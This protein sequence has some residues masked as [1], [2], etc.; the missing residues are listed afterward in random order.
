MNSA[1]VIPSLHPNER[2]IALVKSINNHASSIGKAVQVIIVDDG[3]GKEYAQIFRTLKEELGCTVL[4]HAVNLGKGRALKTAFNFYL[5]QYP[6]GIGL[7]TADSDGQHDVKGIFDCVLALE[8]EPNKLILG[9]REFDKKSIPLR[10]RFG[11]IV[12]RKVFKFLC[13]VNVSDTQTGLRGVPSEFMKKILPLA[14]ERF[15]YEMNMLIETKELDTEIFEVPI[16]TIYIND[17]ES[18]HFN[19]IIDSIK[20]Y[21]VFFKFIFSSLASFIIDISLFTFFMFL[22]KNTTLNAIILATILARICSSLFNYRANQKIVFKKGETK[23]TF[24]KYYLLALVQMLISAFLVS[25]IASKLSLNV[26]LIKIIVDGILF[27]LSF[28]IQRNLIFVEKR[29]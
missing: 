20:I 22:L 9:C 8:K 28:Q 21:A 16:E 1:I 23:K 25:F 13:G 24:L 29:N 2:L 12:T 15:E 10:S 19:P 14:G 26:T 5:S 11:N 27:L 4:T 18:S 7:V 3:S 6:D 17:N